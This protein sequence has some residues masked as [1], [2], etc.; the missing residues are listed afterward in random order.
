MVAAYTQLLA[1]RYRSQLD[2]KAA[3]T[4]FGWR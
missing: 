3:L 4:E 2:E 1:E